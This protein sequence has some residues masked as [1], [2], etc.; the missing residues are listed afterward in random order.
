MWGGSLQSH[1]KTIWNKVE[2]ETKRHKQQLEKKTH[3][4]EVK[5]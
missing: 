2:V 1:E 4:E 5:E 3:T